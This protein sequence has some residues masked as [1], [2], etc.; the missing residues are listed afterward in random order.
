MNYAIA[1][2]GAIIIASIAWWFISGKRFYTGPI[3]EA[4]LLNDDSSG[5]DMP[6]A[7]EKELEA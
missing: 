5:A 2:L 6:G 3:V 7:V 1:F 4:V